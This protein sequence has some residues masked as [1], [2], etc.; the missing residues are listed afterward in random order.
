[1]VVSKDYCK[2]PRMDILKLLVSRGADATEKYRG[3]TVS[4]MR[5]DPEVARVLRSAQI[6]ST[7]ES[8]FNDE[9]AAP[10]AQPSSNS[11]GGF[12]L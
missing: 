4:A 3:K 12:V 2:D 1:M 10:Q 8:A 11:I 6:G 9:E 5:R 7:I